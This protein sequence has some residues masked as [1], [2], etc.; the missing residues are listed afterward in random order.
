MPFQLLLLEGT[1]GKVAGHKLL[2]VLGCCVKVLGI[3]L[4]LTLRSSFI[5]SF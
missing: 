2:K 4:C 5:F 3:N 1:L